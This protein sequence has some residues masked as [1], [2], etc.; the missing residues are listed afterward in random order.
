MQKKELQMKKW[1]MPVLLGAA[2]VLITVSGILVRQNILFL[3]PLYISLVVATM[4]A[5]VSRYAKLIG[6]VNSVF[7]AAVFIYYGLYGNAMNALLVSCTLQLITFFRWR[8]HPWGHSTIFHKMNG[9]LRAAVALGFCALSMG[10]FLVLRGLGSEYQLVDTL[11][12]GVGLLTSFLNMLAYVEYTWVMLPNDIVTIVTY[13]AM[14]VKNPEQLP[15]VIYS[16][17]GFICGCMAFVRVRRLY[18]EQQ[19]AKTSLLPEENAVR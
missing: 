4:N 6:G 14:A 11:S 15:Y 5:R 13:S 16:L 8:K 2:F 1:V 9:R 12:T 7:Y 10:V 18:A 3:M 19:A 17:Y